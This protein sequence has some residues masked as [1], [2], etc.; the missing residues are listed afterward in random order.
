M[1]LKRISKNQEPKKIV[2]EEIADDKTG[3]PLEI[4][5]KKDKRMSVNEYLEIQKMLED[6][7]QVYEATKIL[8]KD[9]TDA[10][11]DVLF[12]ILTLEELGKVRDFVFNNLFP[13]KSLEDKAKE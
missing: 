2:L 7:E 1:A 13:R 9:Y 8:I 10:D 6:E 11:V 4:F 5:E 3:Q 12:D